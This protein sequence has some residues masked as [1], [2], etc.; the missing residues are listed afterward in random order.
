MERK[1]QRIEPLEGGWKSRTYYVVDA[2]FSPDNPISRYVFFTG[3][4]GSGGYPE[5]YN[6]F[7]CTEDRTRISEALYVKAIK[8]LWTEENITQTMFTDLPPLLPRVFKD[9]E[10]CDHPGCLAHVSHPCEV[11]G[12]IA[13][14][15]QYSAQEQML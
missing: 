11:C 15:G 3:F 13:S 9:G 5:G 8:E 14:R 2:C 10:P 12:R 7:C 1:R 4:I 6:E